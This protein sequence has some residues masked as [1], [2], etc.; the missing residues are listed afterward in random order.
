MKQQ[1]DSPITKRLFKRLKFKD[2]IIVADKGYFCFD[3]FEQVQNHGNYLLFP[4]VELWNLCC[5]TTFSDNIF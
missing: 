2:V 4:V 3:T 1:H 5:K